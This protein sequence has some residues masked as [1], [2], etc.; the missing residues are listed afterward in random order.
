MLR[1]FQIDVKDR[2]YSAWH[3]PN[4]FNI[5]PIMATGAGKTVL[6]GEVIREMQTA[7]CGIAH[8]QELVAQ[9]S[10]ALCRE[11]IQ[12]SIIAPKKTQRVIIKLHHDTFG[13]STWHHRADVRVA[14]IDSL[15]AY[16]KTDRWLGQV[17]LVV[18]DEGHHVLRGNK[19]GNGMGLFPNAR[20]LFPTA[21]GLRADGKG[22]GRQGSGLV[23]KFIIGPHARML[24]DR[25]FLTDYQL[26]CPQ[27]DIDF[28]EV[29]I[30]PTTGD[31]VAPKLR[32]VTH[33]SKQIVGDAVKCYLKWA[34]GKL[35]V[36]FAVDVEEAKK[37]AIAFNAL[38]VRAEVITADTP[39]EV[40]GQFM[41]DFRARRI[42]MLVSVDCLGEGVDVPAIEVII[43]ARRTASFQLYAQMFG[44]GL[45]TMVDC[46]PDVWNT[47][48]DAERLYRISISAKPFALVIDL[49]GNFCHHGPPDV[50]REYYLGDDS[51]AN[52]RAT[53][54]I[55]LRPC[56]NPECAQ[57]YERYLPA[58]PYCGNEPVPAGRSAPEQVD[59]DILLLD[60]ETLKAMRAAI[61]KIDG[62]VYMPNAAGPEA[63]KHIF[64]T[65]ME[66]QNAQQILRTTMRL[67]GGWRTHVGETD[68]MA[69]RRFFHTFG[70]D[71]MTAQT[72]GREEAMGLEARIKEQ[73]DK[74][75]VYA[76]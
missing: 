27:S 25:G 3:E 20:G 44:R 75:G 14:G 18:Q 57:P 42:L 21:H 50:P 51:R 1:D 28:S 37:L 76:V 13:Y 63:R 48:S 45:R 36:T 4:V 23:D 74:V 61:K 41:K 6:V 69:H 38:G 58:C 54:A 7:T 55:P 19:W 15:R 31:Y 35:G 33:A 30:S 46:D 68:R 56:V 2:G 12:H 11:R 43:M 8:R 5:M 64:H 65:H 40:R 53:D 34:A 62:A 49:V 10:L 67:W 24:I 22:L 39:I 29:P 26:A 59:G 71:V 66:R 73:L 16:D 47:L 70:I 32:A 9:M 17:G 60:M 72:L 52:E